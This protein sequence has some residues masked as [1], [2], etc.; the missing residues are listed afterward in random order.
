MHSGRCQAE[1]LPHVQSHSGGLEPSHDGAAQKAFLTYV[2]RPTWDLLRNVA[3]RSH[4]LALVNLEA[5]LAQWT[6]LAE[7]GS[8]DEVISDPTRGGPAPL[9]HI[10]P[11]TSPFHLPNSSAWCGGPCPLGPLARL[12]ARHSLS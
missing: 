3:P 9:V 6:L 4:G 1:L 8:R 12:I 10:S 5:N 11:G 2:V 7:R